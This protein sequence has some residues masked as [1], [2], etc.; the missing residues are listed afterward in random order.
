M[1]RTGQRGLPS[2]SKDIENGLR[3]NNKFQHSPPGKPVSIFQP[4]SRIRKSSFSSDPA[5]NNSP[6]CLI[7]E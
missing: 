6:A 2:A 4:V 1:D 5:A 3:P 7:L